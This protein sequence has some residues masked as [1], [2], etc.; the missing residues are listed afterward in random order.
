MGLLVKT[1]HDWGK[2]FWDKGYINRILENGKAKK[3]KIE[4]DM[5]EYPRTVVQ[6]QKI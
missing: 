6:L 5:T 3:T 4:K 2:N 1:G